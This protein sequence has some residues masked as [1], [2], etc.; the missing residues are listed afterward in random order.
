MGRRVSSTLRPSIVHFDETSLY[1]PSLL[2]LF[3]V[4]FYNSFLN[5]T[6]SNSQG[7]CFEDLLQISCIACTCICYYPSGASGV[8]D[9][10][11]K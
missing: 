3:N 2:D 10:R 4:E 9:I 7:Q 5:F 11:K 1:F 6:P 8:K